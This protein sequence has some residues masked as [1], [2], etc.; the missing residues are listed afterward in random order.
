MTYF[1]IL[2]FCNRS[3]A[4]HVPWVINLLLKRKTFTC[5]G[6]PAIAHVQS[7]QFVYGSISSGYNTHMLAIKPSKSL[8]LLFVGLTWH[9]SNTSSSRWK[10]PQ[11]A[12]AFPLNQR[13]CAGLH[14]TNGMKDFSY[15]APE[16]N[17]QRSTV[18]LRGLYW[19]HHNESWL[20]LIVPLMGRMPLT[21]LH[22]WLICYYAPFDMTENTSGLRGNYPLVALVGENDLPT[23]SKGI[24]HLVVA[25]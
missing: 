8:A 9:R 17:N 14:S 18:A 25:T 4:V 1:A 22:H 7:N 13:N 5:H 3:S 10:K 23:M 21:T 2:F 16:S 15:L 6:W 19:M 11:S 12:A 20:E 24:V